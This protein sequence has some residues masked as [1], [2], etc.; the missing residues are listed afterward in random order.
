ME[1]GVETES[2][3]SKSGTTREQKGAELDRGKDAEHHG[4]PTGGRTISLDWSQHVQ[5]CKFPSPQVRAW[6]PGRRYGG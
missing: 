4:S 3:I 6:G 1:Q 2:R 5:N